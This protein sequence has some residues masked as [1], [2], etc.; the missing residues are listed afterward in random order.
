MINDQSMNNMI[1][2]Q[3]LP[4]HS[5]SWWTRK[6]LRSKRMTRWF[7]RPEQRKIVAVSLHNSSGT[8]PTD[9]WVPETISPH[10]SPQTTVGDVQILEQCRPMDRGH[11]AVVHRAI[12]NA[13]VRSCSD[14]IYTE[15]RVLYH[16]LINL[17]R[18]LIPEEIS[19]KMR[20]D[21]TSRVA[22]YYPSRV[23]THTLNCAISLL[24][25]TSSNYAH[26]LT[27]ILP[28]AILWGRNGQGPQVPMLVDAGLHPNI[29]R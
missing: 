25:H 4:E 14:L 26:W 13:T 1:D 2:I 8:R 27:E 17:N 7:Q 16:D 10:T 12:R 6:C 22:T 29:M 20:I 15:H 3:T 18:D 5:L 11:P 21:R 28:K 23:A 24:G 9:E 19:A